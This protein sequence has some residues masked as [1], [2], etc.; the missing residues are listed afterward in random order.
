MLPRVVIQNEISIDGAI[1][2]FGVHMG[3]YY[4]LAAELGT[5]ADM[6]G[7]QTMLVSGFAERAETADDFRCPVPTPGDWRHLWYVP[8]IGARLSGRLHLY[9]NSQWCLD[10][11]IL[12]AEDTAK[13]YREYL[14]ARDYAYI[15][16]DRDHVD[17][18]RLARRSA[19]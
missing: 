9:R 1:D 6:F 5:D 2:G 16:A 15:V 3:T 8:D 14:D 19:S 10:P 12:I 13:C 17:L 7:S 11:V 4:A 18:R